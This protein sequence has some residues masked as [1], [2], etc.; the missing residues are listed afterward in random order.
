M[1][2]WIKGE[3]ALAWNM[4]NCLRILLTVLMLACSLILETDPPT[5]ASRVSM[6]GAESDIPLTD[7]VSEVGLV[8]PVQCHSVQVWRRVYGTTAWR[9]VAVGEYTIFLGHGEGA[10]SKVPA[11][12][13]LIQIHQPHMLVAIGD[14]SCD[15]NCSTS[16]QSHLNVQ[17][18]WLG[19]SLCSF[20]Y[21]LIQQY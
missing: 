18:Q 21:L 2:L 17:A 12:V 3:Y 16:H 7:R 11:E 15:T 1:R 8:M 5:I 9:H 10:A 4:F 13:K 20:A 14:A 19:A 6:R